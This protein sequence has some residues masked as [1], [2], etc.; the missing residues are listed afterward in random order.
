M[1][2]TQARLECVHP[3]EKLIRSE[4]LM[5]GWITTNIFTDTSTAN[6]GKKT[7]S[8]L[9][10]DCF[11]T[12]K[13]TLIKPDLKK[14]PNSG[15]KCVVGRSE[16]IPFP[17]CSLKCLPGFRELDL[18]VCFSLECCSG[19]PDLRQWSQSEGIPWCCSLGPFFFLKPNSI[20]V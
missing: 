11:F 12:I 17:T 13:S 15:R 4:W 1:C 6:G 5:G 3:D 19:I 7:L 16:V 8:S 9:S 20:I 10:V 18:V 2:M 14:V